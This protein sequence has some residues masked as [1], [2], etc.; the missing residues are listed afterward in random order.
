MSTILS[1]DPGIRGVGVAVWRHGRLHAAAWVQNPCSTGSGPREAAEAARAV[2]VHCGL[3]RLDTLVLE[4]PQIYSRGG[5]RTKGDP[6]DLL[7]LAA[8]DG[9]LAALFPEAAVV[10]FTPS[11]WKGQVDKPKSVH[12]EYAIERRVRERLDESELL[13]IVWPGNK[14]HRWDVVDALGVGLH[15]LGRFERKRVFARE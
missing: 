13:R 4:Y 8:V 3:A 5:G 11:V 6:N 14:K 1:I 7:P 2:H 15:H 9:A 10:Y 12:E